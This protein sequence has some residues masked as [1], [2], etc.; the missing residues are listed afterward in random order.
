MS[1]GR[2]AWLG[3]AL[4]LAACSTSTGLDGHVTGNVNAPWSAGA[5]GPGVNPIAVARKVIA[6]VNG[7]C[8][9]PS[10][11]TVCGDLSGCCP[12]ALECCS[13]GPNDGLCAP[14]CTAVYETDGCPDDS[15]TLCGDV[16]CPDACDATGSDCEG[17]DTTCDPTTDPT[18]SNACDPSTDPSCGSTTCDPTTDPSCSSTCDPST[19]PS[20][21]DSSSSSGSGSSSGSDCDPSG[22]ACGNCCSGSCDDT[23]SYCL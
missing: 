16:C 6:L 5:G 2:W 1:R 18:C 11:E 3:L 9:D 8:P 15:P 12:D 20:C 22:A 10:T 23:G 21:G 7:L 17:A 13:G 14:D 19:D 4:G